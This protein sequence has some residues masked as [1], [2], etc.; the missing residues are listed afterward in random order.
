MNTN[1][2]HTSPQA[3]QPLDT[4]PE[5]EI[6]LL[7]QEI[8][9][10][11]AQLNEAEHTINTFETQIRTRL[12]LEI[13]RIR[14]LTT[15]YK[16]QKNTK[17]AKRLEQKKR[18]KNYRE[19]QGVLKTRPGT[20]EG[21]TLSSGEQQELK[22]LYK[23]AIVHVHPDK[24]VNED[25]R[26]GEQATAVTV[27]LNAIYERGDLGQLKDFHEHIISGNAMAHVPYQP[28]PVAD[29]NALRIYLRKKRDQMANDFAQIKQLH[30]YTVVTTYADPLSFVDEL[31]IQF[32]QRIQQLEKRTRTR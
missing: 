32:I 30:L 4:S 5:T 3:L 12:H 11:E 28:G 2:P 7:E 26:T 9:Q 25:A 18:G 14:E 22:R 19:P 16:D 10:L 27:A 23:E 29:P 13:Q 24:F 20:K 17:K 15:L 21:G 6:R 1:R 8:T 31:R